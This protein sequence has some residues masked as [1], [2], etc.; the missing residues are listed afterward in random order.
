VEV[1]RRNALGLCLDGL[2]LCR[3]SSSSDR[4]IE[5]LRDSRFR[6]LHRKMGVEVKRGQTTPQRPAMSLLVFDTLGKNY[7]YLAFLVC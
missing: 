2:L 5:V 4:R 1:V 7:A 3:M 6:Y